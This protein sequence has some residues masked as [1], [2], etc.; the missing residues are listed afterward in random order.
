MERELGELS[1]Q[2]ADLETDFGSLQSEMS[3]LYGMV[4]E[5]QNISVASTQFTVS[6]VDDSV[7]TYSYTVD[8]QG[9][10]TSIT[11]VVG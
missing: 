10:M 3:G 7:S 4:R 8:D 6:F 1:S 2:F 9:R 5:V 11:K